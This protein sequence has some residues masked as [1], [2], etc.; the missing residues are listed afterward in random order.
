MVWFELWKV[1]IAFIFKQKF[2]QSMIF[3]LSEIQLW[4][5]RKGQSHAYSARCDKLA[6]DP[7]TLSLQMLGE[8]LNQD[9]IFLHT[10]MLFL[11]SLAC[12]AWNQFVS[13]SVATYALS[14]IFFCV[15][16]E[17]KR[18]L[19]SAL[20]IFSPL[21]LPRVQHTSWVSQKT[22]RSSVPGMKLHMS[23]CDSTTDL[24]QISPSSA[25]KIGPLRLW[26][27]KICVNITFSFVPLFVDQ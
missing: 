24:I 25:K 5:V 26:I 7:S 18:S 13:A 3:R 21:E 27:R 20:I 4:E 16:R 19:V 11:I 15:F 2:K 6:F 1:A 9:N 23:S 8:K 17:V 14:M 10:F 12:S 22:T